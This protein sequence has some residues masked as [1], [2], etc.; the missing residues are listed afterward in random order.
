[1]RIK[2][3]IRTPV[4]PP[5]TNATINHQAETILAPVSHGLANCQVLLPRPGCADFHITFTNPRRPLVCCFG[6]PKGQSQYSLNFDL[7]PTT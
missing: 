3:I 5:P 7:N 2:A 1:M 6:G 4:H